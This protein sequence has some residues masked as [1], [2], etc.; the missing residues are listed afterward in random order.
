MEMQGT[1]VL[2]PKQARKSPMY[3]V[4][5]TDEAGALSIKEC[6]A[7]K[8]EAKRFVQSLPDPTVVKCMYRVSAVITPKQKTVVSF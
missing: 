3:A 1:D 8:T 4:I 6:P 5:F 7:G 2:P